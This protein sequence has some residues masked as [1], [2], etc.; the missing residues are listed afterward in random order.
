MN[1]RRDRNVS[2]ILSRASGQLLRARAVAALIAL[3]SIATTAHAQQ[4]SAPASVPSA[5]ET[6]LASPPSVIEPGV[7][8]TPAEEFKAAISPDNRTLLY[9]VTERLFRHMTVVQA[10]RQGAHWGMPQVAAF[11]GIWRDGDPSFAPDGKSLLFI[12]NRPLPGD[13]SGG[14]RRDFNIWMVERKSDGTW[15]EP[16]ALER[17]INTDTAE[18][19]P[20]LTTGGTLYFSRGDNMFSALKRGH[21]FDTPVRLSLQGGD[22]AISPDGR[23]LVFD[24]DGPVPGDADLFVSCQTASGW[25]PPSRF[26]EPVNSPQEEGDPTISA[27]GQTLYF[28][29]RHAPPPDRAPRPQRATY[30]DIHRDALENIYNGSRNLYQVPLTPALCTAGGAR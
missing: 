21:G 4:P 23:V 22:P 27:D 11:S 6:R 24:A 3:L 7:I 29:S 14:P 19:A 8:S 15:G 28:F 12:S 30:A 25:S 17:S 2:E 16:M 5:P 13:S 1:V 9:V 10:E 20:S 26:A 18:F